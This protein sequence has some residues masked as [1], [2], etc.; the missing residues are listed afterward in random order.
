[1]QVKEGEE[2]EANIKRMHQTM[3]QA[4]DCNQDEGGDSIFETRIRAS[5]RSG[6]ISENDRL[7]TKL[8]EQRVEHELQLTELRSLLKTREQEVLLMEERCSKMIQEDQ[9][10]HKESTSQMVK[11]FED[12]TA[13]LNYEHQVE[14]SNIEIKFSEELTQKSHMISKLKKKLEQQLDQFN[15]ELKGKLKEQE[16]M[17]QNEIQQ[18]QIRDL[19][20]KAKQA[21][22]YEELKVER[23]RNL[24]EANQLKEQIK[25]QQE[26]LQLEKGQLRKQFA[27]QL[28]HLKDELIQAEYERNQLAKQ[29]ECQRL[30]SIDFPVTKSYMSSNQA[31]LTL[32]N[33]GFNKL[34]SNGP[35]ET[36]CEIQEKPS[37][38]QLVSS[39]ELKLFKSCQLMVDQASHMQCCHCAQI[40]P[41]THFYDHLFEEGSQCLGM[42]HERQMTL[43]KNSY[44]NEFTLCYDQDASQNIVN[45]GSAQGLNRFNGQQLSVNQSVSMS[46]DFLKQSKKQIPPYPQ[47]HGRQ[48]SFGLVND[49]ELA[50]S[51][52]DQQR[53]HQR[54]D[55]IFN[56][57]RQSSQGSNI[58]GYLFQKHQKVMSF[59]SSLDNIQQAPANQTTSFRLEE[60]SQIE[61]PNNKE[62]RSY[63]MNDTQNDFVNYNYGVTQG[64]DSVI[65]E[66]I[67][68]SLNPYQPMQRI[69]KCFN[70][71]EDIGFEGNKSTYLRPSRN[72]EMSQLGNSRSVSNVL[73]RDSDLQISTASKMIEGNNHAFTVETLHREATIDT[74]DVIHGFEREEKATQVVKQKLQLPKLKIQE[75]IRLQNQVH[76]SSCRLASTIKGLKKEMSSALQEDKENILPKMAN[77]EPFSL[78]Q[79]Q[80]NLK[81][82]TKAPFT[83]RNKSSNRYNNLLESSISVTSSNNFG[84]LR[85]DLINESEL[86]S[87]A[88]Q[89]H[90]DTRQKNHQQISFLP[91]QYELNVHPQ[92]GESQEYTDGYGDEDLSPSQ[93]SQSLLSDEDGYDALTPLPQLYQKQTYAPIE[94]AEN[95]EDYNEEHED[96][97]DL[98]SDLISPSYFYSND[99]HV[100]LLRSNSELLATNREHRQFISK[101]KSLDQLSNSEEQQPELAASSRQGFILQDYLDEFRLKQ[102]EM[103][104]PEA[105]QLSNRHHLG[106]HGSIKPHLMTNQQI[107]FDQFQTFSARLN[108]EWSQNDCGNQKSACTGFL[109]GTRD[110]GSSKQLTGLWS[111]QQNMNSS[112]PRESCPSPLNEHEVGEKPLS[113]NNTKYVSK[114]REQPNTFEYNINKVKPCMTQ[115]T[116]QVLKGGIAQ[117]KLIQALPQSQLRLSRRK[118]SPTLGNKCVQ[119]PDQR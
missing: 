11:D 4:L 60:N 97:E 39:T 81:A 10:R 108:R 32:S 7:K 105:G 40:L 36:K 69:E 1:M 54:N 102:S 16:Q 85:D 25:S 49:G 33:L 14:F 26:M 37:S 75:A 93:N 104:L 65:R 79:R 53:A 106:T 84:T 111:L 24:L 57:S 101:M 15:D 77:I 95:Y 45:L 98:P 72:R 62:G 34:G 113:L 107:K 96:N 90:Y 118:S 48:K 18:Y 55:S 52:A 30:N 76:P 29:L 21:E 13:N 115:F 100:H 119:I 28:D 47:L 63:F 59:E 103:L 41:T 38:Q 89:P 114:G 56:R 22:K 50:N 42:K 3:M 91:L 78:T 44:P 109:S 35:Q 6:S 17:H 20:L 87:D 43:D 12:K 51:K 67:N 68:N 88:K 64:D 66:P 71:E 61:Y 116:S 5:S 58:G 80:E 99:Q 94:I 31:P 112:I 46:K 83:A 92:L 70:D 19:Q 23:D 74:Q 117:P 73:Q 9:Q 8:E 110:A 2:R 27:M 86:E 82:L